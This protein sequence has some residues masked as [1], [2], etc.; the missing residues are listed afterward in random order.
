MVAQKGRIISGNA[1]GHAYDLFEGHTYYVHQTLHNAFAYN[2][3]DV[4]ISEALINDTVNDILQDKE[5]SFLTQLSLLNYVQKETLIAIAKDIKA[6]EVT[7]VSFIKR[8]SLQSPSSVQNAIRHLLKLQMVTYHVE[9]KTKVY[10]VSDRF[11]Q[12]WIARMY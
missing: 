4:E 9:G 6:S 12:M 8:H 5:H 10:S 3:P 11:L 7:S 2:E 1:A